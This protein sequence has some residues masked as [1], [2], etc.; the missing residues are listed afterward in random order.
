VPSKYEKQVAALCKEYNLYL[1]EI[2][3]KEGLD[4]RKIGKPLKL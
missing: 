1:I 2:L 4:I 3:Q